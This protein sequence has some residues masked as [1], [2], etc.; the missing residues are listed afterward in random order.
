MIEELIWISIV[1]GLIMLPAAILVFRPF[2]SRWTLTAI[3][4]YL[5]NAVFAAWYL[6]PWINWSYW[7][8][9]ALALISLVSFFIGLAKIRK[10]GWGRPS[11]IVVA[12]TAPLLLFG[13]YLS[14]LNLQ[15]IGARQLPPDAVDLKSPLRGGRFAVTQGG[16]APPLQA[17]HSNSRS[18]Q[19]A[20]DLAKLNG[21][22]TGSSEYLRQEDFTTSETWDLPVYAPCSGRVVWS[23]DGIEDSRDFDKKTPA[24]NVIG[25]DCDGV[26]VS[27]AHLRK[28]SVAVPE[29]NIIS[30]GQLVGRIGM[31]GRTFD[32]HLHMHAERGPLKRDFS[33]NPGVAIRLEGMV[34]YTGLIMQ[35][36][37]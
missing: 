9:G 16:S 14:T 18:Q 10:A 31:S 5:A 7:L 36:K 24:G 32:P 15:S 35:V 2:A 6:A 28:G 23:R 3:L 26:I 34:P 8:Y 13:L 25:I 33:D 12:G 20:V 19:Y 11:W 27:L 37:P 4:F 22:L 17:G 1:V 30:T 29:G 21:A